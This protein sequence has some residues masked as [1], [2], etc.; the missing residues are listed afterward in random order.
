MSS[1]PDRWFLF[2]VPAVFSALFYWLLPQALPT[3][4][5]LAVWLVGAGAFTAYWAWR[6]ET[7]DH[8]TPATRAAGPA[9]DQREAALFASL[10]QGLG[11]GFLAVDMQQK[12]LLANDPLSVLF[13]RPAR[14]A[15]GLPL[16]EV[17]RHREIN[18]IVGQTL[19]QGQE[20][21]RDVA[22]ALPAPGVWKVRARPFP[23]EGPR[24]GVLVTFNDLSNLRRLEALRKDFVA[25]V[26]HE[27]RTPL[28]ALR[29]ALETLLEGALDD[30]AAARDFLETAQNQVDR[31]QRLIDD[32]LVL[33]RLDKG[34]AKAPPGTRTP[35][36]A[37]VDKV[38][39]V[40]KPVAQKKKVVFE[41]NWPAETV[42]V[43][44]SSD[45]VAQ[46]FMNLLDNA[47]KF[48][49]PGGRISLTAAVRD[50]RTEVTVQDSG[51]GIPPEDLP[52]VFER[53]Y[54]VDKSRGGD[55]GGTGLGLAI[56]KH[57]VE[58]AGGQVSAASAPGQGARFTVS[59]PTV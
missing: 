41:V 53:F 45:H 40:L 11:E 38:V 3:W 42:F 28:T 47:V 46:V 30:R 6:E 33:S 7:T 1:F 19:A 54:R 49:R 35:L 25:N 2:A 8:F 27:L 17:L 48:N 26:S 12:I 24:A 29:A 21:E 18:E 52:R 32:L 23:L 43:P 31:L 39:K 58:N 50:G 5:R 51:P 34:E 55:A 36:D 13:N 16:W 37:T 9:A 4:A 22:V 10:W 15:R 20:I 56:V 57:I 44:L 14:Q 59:F